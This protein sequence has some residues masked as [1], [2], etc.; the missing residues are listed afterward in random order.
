MFLFSA[1]RIFGEFDGRMK[2]NFDEIISVSVRFG[3]YEH[4]NDC[5]RFCLLDSK[6]LQAVRQ[7]F[8]SSHLLPHRR[9]ILRRKPSIIVSSNKTWIRNTRNDYEDVKINFCSD[10]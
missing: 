2:R 3:L 4:D 8:E 1:E 6:S 10:L 5:T 7:K 9:R